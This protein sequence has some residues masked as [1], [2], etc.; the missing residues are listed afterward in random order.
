MQLISVIDW[1]FEL[2][3]ILEKWL[4][5]IPRDKVLDIASPHDGIL[6]LRENRTYI[7]PHGYGLFVSW[8]VEMLWSASHNL[9]KHPSNFSDGDHAL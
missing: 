4:L 9:K 1:P 6:V 2:E 8:V 3:T 5:S 7:T